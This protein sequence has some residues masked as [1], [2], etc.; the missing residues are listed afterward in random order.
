MF[1]GMIQLSK[2]IYRE[3]LLQSLAYPLTTKGNMALWWLGQ[4][5]FVI[6]HH[7][8]MFDFNTVNIDGAQRTLQQISEA[9][10]YFLAKIG[11]KY[12]LSP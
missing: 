1:T 10:R 9:R 3:R 7:F 6:C 8:G 5:G 4:A 11:I 12:I 2:E